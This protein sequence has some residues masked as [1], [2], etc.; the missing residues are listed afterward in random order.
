MFRTAGM[1]NLF[2]TPFCLWAG[3]FI[4]VPLFCMAWYAFT[5]E[6][7]FF[8]LENFTLAFDRPYFKALVLSVAL[9][10]A[11]TIICL[12]LAYPLC[13]ILTDKARDL[14]TIVSLLFIL[15]L[16]MNSLLLTMAWQTILEKNGILNQMLRY[17]SLPDANLIN[18]PTA[19]IIGMVYN[20][21][22]YMV[23][24]LY[25]SLSKIDKRIIEAAR[26]LGA[27]Y[28]QTFWK[29]ILPLSLPGAVSGITMVF[30]PALTTFVISA[31]LGG[32][33]L[34]LIGNV[35]EQEFVAGYNWHWGAGLSMILMIFIV[36]NMAVTA[37]FDTSHEEVEEK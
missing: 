30:I 11:S 28:M 9:A 5:D 29:V 17:F 22:P 32:G 14:S 1:R 3:I 16:W 12:I 31:L 19:I 13:L 35:I 7:G 33:K 24:P 21:L 2:M 36:V 4:F 37:F 6:S 20:F 23:L 8:T 27:S 25:V 18:T 26:D 34:L 15:P 10:L